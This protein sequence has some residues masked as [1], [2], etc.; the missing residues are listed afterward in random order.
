MRKWWYLLIGVFL[1]GLV[2]AGIHFL[3]NFQE[4]I[5]PVE[6]V[7]DEIHLPPVRHNSSVSLEATLLTRRSVRK[8]A[9][10]PLSLE[11]VSQLLWAAQGITDDGGYRTAPSAGALYPLEVYLLAGD[12]VG[13][14]KG[15]YKYL[16]FGHTII[17]VTSQ[18]RRVDLHQAALKQDAIIQAP[19]VIVLAAVYDRT[20]AKYGDRAPQYVHIEAGSVAQNVYLQA[21]ALDL[22]TVLIGA[23]YDNQ[24]KAVVG[25][26]KDEEPLALMPVG[27]VP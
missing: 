11:E 25:L 9:D 19:A 12:V 3:V 1:L 7:S 10:E 26:A 2:L 16:P 27:R 8:Y 14:E 22:G 24:V 4:V 20:K 17:K 21:T 15:V 13:L 23:F 5:R 18:D 6:T